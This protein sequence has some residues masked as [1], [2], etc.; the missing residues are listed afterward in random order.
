MIRAVRV[1]LVVAGLAGIAFG[2]WSMREF[3]FVQLRSAAVWL[4]G[5][6]IA[7]DLVLA[8]IVALLGAVT[9]RI[10]PARWRTPVVVVFVL[11]GS[12][13]LVALP[14]LSGLGARPDNPSLLDRPY[15]PAWLLLSALAALAVPV[16]VWLRRD[17]GS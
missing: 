15:L 11:W 12:L 6:V 7:H 9:W 4:V 3:E 1:A 17:D 14:V 5:G 16:Y 8:P 13:T 2:L 10:A